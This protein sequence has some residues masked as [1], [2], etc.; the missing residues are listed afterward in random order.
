MNAM[1]SFMRDLGSL[2]NRRQPLVLTLLE[3]EISSDSWVLPAGA[4]IEPL[5]APVR[6]ETPFG[7]YEL[8][9]SSP[10]GRVQVD[11]VFEPL[12]ERVMPRD[13]PA[14]R[15]F[16]EAIARAEAGVFKVRLAPR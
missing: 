15:T 6:L 8:K 16:L 9:V 12:V 2:Q 11:S 1:R 10:A 5:P 13:Y 3:R 7:T 14:F 4:S